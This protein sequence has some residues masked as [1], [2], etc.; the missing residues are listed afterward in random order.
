[1]LCVS[2][3]GRRWSATQK[4][5]HI[6]IRTNRK[7]RLSFENLVAHTANGRVR[8]SE[9]ALE[10]LPGETSYSIPAQMWTRP[11]FFKK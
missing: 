2:L 9:S 8:L 4:K 10:I 11:L 1:M 6:R 5:R 7:D 3:F